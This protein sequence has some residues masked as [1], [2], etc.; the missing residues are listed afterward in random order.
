[1][2]CSTTATSSPAIPTWWRSAVA[3]ADAAGDPLDERCSMRPSA[4]SKASRR[5]RRKD[6]ELVSEAVR[7]AV[8]GGGHEVWGK[9]PLVTVFVTR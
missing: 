8:R 1:M 7:R 6:F 2:S 4:R 5:A 3:E 9:K